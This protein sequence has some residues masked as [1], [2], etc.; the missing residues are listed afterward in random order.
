MERLEESPVQ[1]YPDS[2]RERNMH[3]LSQGDPAPFQALREPRQY[4]PCPPGSAH[5]HTGEL[6]SG[7]RKSIWLLFHYISSTDQRQHMFWRLLDE[8][9]PGYDPQLAARYGKT[10]ENIYIEADRFLDRVLQKIDKNTVLLVM[11]DHGFNPFRRCFNL[12][13][14]LFET[15]YHRLRNPWGQQGGSLFENTD[16]SRTSAYGIGL[17]G[18]YINQRGRGRDGIVNPG[19]DSENLIREIASRLEQ[20]VDPK[21][22]ARATLHAL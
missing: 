19:A 6:R 20:G 22:G 15:G 17:N 2:E 16:W 9:H 10:V 11:S 21:T 14:W 3:V 4:R 5:F 1:P 13:T 18:L 7:T 8:R 12:N